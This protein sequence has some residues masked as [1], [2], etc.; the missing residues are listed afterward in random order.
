MDTPVKFIFSH[1]SVRTRRSLPNMLETLVFAHFEQ[2]G[3]LV[4]PA[5]V[6]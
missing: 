6:S 1:R 5:K 4:T 2:H 3:P